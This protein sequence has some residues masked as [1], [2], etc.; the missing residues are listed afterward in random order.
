MKM[1]P[2]Q[3]QASGII[4]EYDRLIGRVLKKDKAAGYAFR[5]SEFLPEGTRPG[6]VAG[7]PPGKRAIALDVTKIQGVV[8]LKADDHFD[9]LASWPVDLERT[10]TGGRGGSV[11]S[12]NPALQAAISQ[13]PKR[14]GVRT[15]V[16]AGVV[17]QPA[18]PV[19][20][21][22]RRGIGRPQ[23]EQEIIIAVDPEEIAPLTEALTTDAEITCV[24][25][26]GRPGDPGAA[27]V[28][29]GHNPVPNVKA[30]EIISGKRSQTVAFP[31]GDAGPAELPAPG[32]KSSTVVTPP[33]E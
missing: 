20:S 17:V 13:Q 16:H 26:S 19:K 32:N 29:P 14:A 6:L 4:L 33:K 28:T 23:P 15:I 2:E 9:L 1:T 5:E 18:Q 21:L 12:P 27:S 8:Y 3:K 7:I 30:V 24:A 25:R 10:L 22:P 11:S 31:A